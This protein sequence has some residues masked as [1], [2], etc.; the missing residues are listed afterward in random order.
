M[1][2]YKPLRLW[3]LSAYLI[4]LSG[5]AAFAF[6]TAFPAALLL[7]AGEIYFSLFSALFA[8]GYLYCRDWLLGGRSIGKRLCGLSVVDRRTG[9]LPSG[10][11]LLWKNLCYFIFPFDALVLLLSGRSVGERISGT[12]VIQENIPAPLAKKRLVKLA[13][14]AAAL[15]LLFGSI[16]S[17]GLNQSKENESYALALAYLTE[18]EA[19]DG[20][21]REDAHISLTGF[22]STESAIVTHS[23]TFETRL[24]FYVVT[25]HQQEDGTWAVCTDCTEF[26]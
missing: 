10:R 24:H 22:V 13:A 5:C 1:T 7:P 17:Y 26:D 18:S 8:I 15:A 21:E 6:L 9:E 12:A 14:I 11:H 4:D 23:Y 20:A 25:C 16:A 3:R 2:E 19:F